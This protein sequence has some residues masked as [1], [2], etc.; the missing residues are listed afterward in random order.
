MLSPIFA[1]GVLAPDGPQDGAR[2]GLR[3]FC[4]DG[5]AEGAADGAAVA[6]A[7]RGAVG[8]RGRCVPRGAAAGGP[9]VS[10]GGVSKGL[11]IKFGRRMG[12]G[13]GFV[14]DVAS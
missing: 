9:E 8:L 10:K 7:V 13:W 1:S 2:D 11:G 6:G 12:F 5:A 3:E 14:L 4:A